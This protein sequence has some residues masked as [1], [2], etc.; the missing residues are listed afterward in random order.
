MYLT[1]AVSGQ[2]PMRISSCPLQGLYSIR[3]L[4]IH[5]TVKRQLIQCCCR[6][7]RNSQKKRQRSSLLFERRTWMPHYPFSSK[8]DLKVRFWKNIHFGR[9]GFGLVY[10]R[11]SF[12]FKKHP[13]SAKRPFFYYSFSSNHPG[14]K[15]VE[16]GMEL[17]EFRP[18]TAAT[19]FAFSSV[20]FFFYCVVIS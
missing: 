13:C 15:S 8:Y 4:G 10:T 9:V 14:A 3:T 12:I 6:R 17:N 11:C 19:T 1:K 2:P 16:C 5:Y 7:R 18:Q 20:C